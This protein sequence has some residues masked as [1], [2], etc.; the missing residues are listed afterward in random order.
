MIGGIA[1]YAAI[2]GKA[3]TQRGLEQRYLVTGR[4]AWEHR[5]G[6]LK[7]VSPSRCPRRHNV[8]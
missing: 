6:I 4:R 3:L 5:K 7:R 8:R 2:L 1:D